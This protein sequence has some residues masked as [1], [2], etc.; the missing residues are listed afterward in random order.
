MPSK[1]S[2]AKWPPVLSTAQLEALTLYATTYAL[3][4]GLLYLPAALHQPP[5]PTSAIHAPLSLFPSPMPRGL[6]EHARKLQK[7]YNVL[8]ARIAMDVSFL[9]RVMGEIDGVGKVDDFV[10]TLWRGWKQLRDEK[11]GLAQVSSL[12]WNYIKNKCADH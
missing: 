1:F 12:S 5:A 9:D 3:S 8:Y 2:H 6:F 10:G 11:K 4:H 7:A